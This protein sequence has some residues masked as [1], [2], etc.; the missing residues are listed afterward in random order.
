MDETIEV[1]LK[2]LILERYKSVLN[3]TKAIGIPYSTID[4]VFKRGINTVNI[5]TIIRIC[6]FLGISADG[7]GEG[8]IIYNDARP[9]INNSN[10]IIALK[11]NGERLQYELS[12]AE[13]QAILTI[14]EG[15]KN[16][17]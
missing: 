3:F 11:C 8:K 15:M 1:K 9:N 17:K 7:L 16:N 4:S 10:Q 5:T 13:M 14:L 12:E 6:Q 2:K